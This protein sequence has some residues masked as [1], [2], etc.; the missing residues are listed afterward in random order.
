VVGKSDV[1]DRPAGPRIVLKA[2]PTV[3]Q[4]ADRL[5]PPRPEGLEIYLD[6]VDI[7]ESDWLDVLRARMAVV[8]PRDFALLVEGPVRSLD[9]TFFDLT[10]DSAANRLVVDRLAT[11]GRA[12]GAQAAC[13]HL[14]SA[15]D[16]LS[17]VTADEANGLVD[18]CQP[19]ANYYAARCAEA[20]LVP[21]VENVPP[22]ARMRES[23][24]MTSTVGCAPEHLARLA[25]RV[26]GLR[27]TLDT[28]HAQLF[29]NA[30]G[31]SPEGD[32]RFTTLRRALARI[33]AART[34]ADFVE[35]LRGRIETVHVSD[36]EGL[37]GEGLPYGEGTMDLDAAIDRLLPETKWFVTEI[38]E[39]AP[40]RS[41]YMRAAWARISARRARKREA[42]A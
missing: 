32:A 25:D 12:V 29:L 9:G 19:L 15:T 14:I 10:L 27:F 20:G 42:A 36:A 4:L 34:M 30:V 35:P 39:P 41:E 26:A 22:V 31:D 11:F 5:R 23:R 6:A 18:A 17:G 16:D 38:L 13:V 2:R 7:A 40:N 28:S 33:S 37:L 8:P 21:T 1:R 3:E 24:F